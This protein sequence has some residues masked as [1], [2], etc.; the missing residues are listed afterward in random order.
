MSDVLQ[1]ILGRLPAKSFAAA[2]CVSRSWN[3][4][5]RQILSRPRLATALSL[6]PDPYLGVM[7]VID[8]VLS[9]P[10]RPHFAIAFVSTETCL[11]LVHSMVTIHLGS[12]VP[13]IT[14]ATAGVIGKD[15]ITNRFK[16]VKWDVI[17]GEDEVLADDLNRGIGL[18][19]GFLPGVKTS[20]FPLLHTKSDPHMAMVDKFVSDIRG[21]TISV[22]GDEIPVGVMM[23]GDH[24]SDFGPII[25]EIDEKMP[26]ETIVIGDVSS[27]VKC[28]NNAIQDFDQDAYYVDAVG[29]VFAKDNQYN[30]EGEIKFHVGI[31]SGIMPC[32]PRL[33]VVD[34]VENEAG[35][36]WLIAKS[37]D[38][39][40][41]LDASQI[42]QTLGRTI[43]DESYALYIGVTQ[44]KMPH[45]G[46]NP[47]KYLAFHDLLGTEQ[48][49]FVVAGTGIKPGDTFL[50]YH[51][52]S[53]TARSS[54]V[55]V[56]NE[57]NRIANP[58]SM[59]M[60]PNLEVFGG[61]I[62][63]CSN[64]GENFFGEPKVDSMPLRENFPRAPLCGTF[65]LAP[66]ARR[67]VLGKEN[68]E[69]CSVPVFSAVY[70]AMTFVPSSP[71][72]PQ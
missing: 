58:I 5:S 34:V 60:N 55:N 28:T 30:H 68:V 16:E 2:A 8:K 13:L 21:Y 72:P 4:A 41:L 47:P 29:L 14:N 46:E 67:A 7:E 57:F 44:E 19:V 49:M 45:E 23:F 36:S 42:I 25:A 11:H 31:S 32:G 50:L 27:C 69:R 43:E 56:F 1:N 26:I 38:D 48:E 71:P 33:E 24:H 59:S 53:D 20:I 64:R 35:F 51:S 37:M 6:N 12:N 65:C 40:G 61:M 10:I 15:G 66:F 54:C 3:K 22:S 18:V 39:A 63:A 62:F 9:R 70:L 17:Y 52:D